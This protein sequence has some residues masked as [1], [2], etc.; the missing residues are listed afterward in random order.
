MALYQFLT[1][2]LTKPAIERQRTRG[3]EEGRKEGRAVGL[4]EANQQWEE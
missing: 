1:N 3:R 2:T 4:A